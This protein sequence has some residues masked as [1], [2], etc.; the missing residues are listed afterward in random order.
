MQGQLRPSRGCGKSADLVRRKLG[1]TVEQRKK[2]KYAWT[3]ASFPKKM[4][5]TIYAE[6][7]LLDYLKSLTKTD[8]YTVGLI[9]GQ[10]HD[11]NTSIKI[12]LTIIKHMY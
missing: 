10:V 3:V 6:E 7:R 8:G 1:K 11:I 9:L 4:G 12:C 5:R 2:Q